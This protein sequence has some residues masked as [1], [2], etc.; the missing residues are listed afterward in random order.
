VPVPSDIEGPAAPTPAEQQDQSPLP[1]LAFTPA[2]LRARRDGWTPAHQRQFIFHLAHGRGVD[3]AARA[4]ARSRQT[5]YALRKRAG[6][7]GF[8]AAWD[9]A[10]VFAGA[11]R[12]AGAAC[13]S[14]PGGLAGMPEMLLVPRFY[15]GRLIGYVLRE[16]LSALVSALRRLDRLDAAE[17]AK[18][19]NI[20]PHA[21]ATSSA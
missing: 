12:A 18:A 10:L 20:A 7:E 21:P 9:A 11:A 16:D 6:A 8:A 1:F 14:L 13:A 15:R 17:A 3:E 4:V 2:P 5:A 19:D